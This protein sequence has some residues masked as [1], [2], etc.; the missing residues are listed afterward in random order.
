MNRW[1]PTGIVIMVADDVSTSAKMNSFQEATKLTRLTVTRPGSAA[2]T[3]MREGAEPGRAVDQG[4]F[5]HLRRDGS[6]I[7]LQEPDGE[8]RDEGT[9]GEDQDAIGVQD[10]DL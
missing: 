10:V 6:E 1:M 3:A 8:G 9:V 7:A 2:G 5:L 4:G